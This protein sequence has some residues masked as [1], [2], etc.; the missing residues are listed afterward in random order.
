MGFSAGGHLASTAGTHFNK[1][2][3][4][5]EKHTSVRPDFMILIYAV[6]SFKPDITHMGSRDQLIGKHP[7]P[8]KAEL[9]SSELQV[10][11]QT[12]P[13]FLVHASDDPAVTPENS[14]VFYQALLKNKVPAEM[15][16]YQNGGHGFGM[17]NKTTDQ[18]WMDKCRSWMKSNG[19]L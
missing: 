10:T 13:T 4:P 9:Y 18:R 12:P 6:L 14:V 17:V 2:V 1:A 3:V 7:S 8:D 5:N 15:H 16:I 19:W 11:Q